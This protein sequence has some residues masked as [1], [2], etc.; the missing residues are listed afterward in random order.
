[1]VTLEGEFND[2]YLGR[3]FQLSL[4]KNLSNIYHNRGI[5]NLIFSRKT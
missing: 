3:V 4:F 2:Y 5:K 1:M